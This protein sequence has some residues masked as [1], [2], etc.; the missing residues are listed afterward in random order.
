MSNSISAPK[1]LM[2]L[3]GAL[4]KTSSGKLRLAAVLCL[5]VFIAIAMDNVVAAWIALPK[6]GEPT[7]RRIGPQE[8]PQ[9]LVAGSSL[10]LFGISWP[11]VSQARDQGVESWGLGGSA[12]PVW[13]VFQ[14]RARNID[15][16]IIGVSTFDL[17]EHHMCDLCGTLVPLT[18]TIRDLWDTQPGWEFSKRLLAQYPL[19]YIR[20]PFP[21][22]GRTDTVLVGLRRKLPTIL[23]PSSVADDRERAT[24]LPTEAVLTF[25]GSTERL[26]DWPAARTLR[27]LA[28]LRSE[29][30]GR[31]L[32]RGPKSQAFRRML[33]RAQADGRVAVIVMPVSPT[34][35]REFL[36]SDVLNQ[37]ETAL[38]TVHRD[39]PETRFIRLDQVSALRSDS[40]FSDLVHLNG[41][42]RR[43][44]DAE[45]LQSLAR[46][47]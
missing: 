20:I 40:L 30:R 6:I 22:A 38:A 45:F 33:Q 34:Y 28:N 8:G 15:F 9:V 12:P 11:L 2:A 24:V 41:D 4:S 47:Y 29:N 5:A 10:L 25:G 37:F 17:N 18:Q 3:V 14:A 23:R 43:I 35:A 46:G 16:T 27:R 36:T 19:F 1:P 32:F 44:A 21:T 39:F 26:S 31:H 13:E 7:Y 42:G